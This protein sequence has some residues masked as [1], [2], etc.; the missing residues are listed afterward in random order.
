MIKDLTS[1]DSPFEIG[2][3][4]TLREGNDVRTVACGIMVE[5]ALVAAE[6]PDTE[7]ISAMV[8]NVS[9]IKTPDRKEI[10]KL[11]HKTGLVI[12]AEEHKIIGGLGTA[13]A[14]ALRNEKFPVEF[15]GINDQFRVSCNDAE[16]LPELNGLTSN[17][18]FSTIKDSLR[19]KIK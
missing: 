1:H 14:E 7:K 5:R 10:I 2:K 18:I 8:V 11:S 6:M 9:T 13:V 3:G 4:Y 15:I 17:A 19:F 16:P 12:T